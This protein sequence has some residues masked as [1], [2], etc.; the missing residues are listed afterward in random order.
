[1]FVKRSASEQRDKDTKQID[2]LSNQWTKASSDL[3]EQ[4][5]VAVMLEKDLES[6]KLD[7]EKTV[8]ELTNNVATVSSNLAKVETSLKTAEEQIKE[9]DTKIAD[10]ENQNQ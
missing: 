3:E 4:K 5:K 8:A 10:L 2:T 9:R 7:Y 6:K 1:M